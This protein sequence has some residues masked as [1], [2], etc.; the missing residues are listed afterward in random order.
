MLS[1]DHYLLIKK[2]LLGEIFDGFEYPCNV[3]SSGYRI[4]YANRAFCRYYGYKIDQVI[5]LS[6]K[7]LLPKN[8]QPKKITDLQKQIIIRKKP[9]VG[10]IV[11]VNSQGR[12]SVVFLKVVP[13]TPLSSSYPVAH[14]SISCDRAKKDAMLIS[15]LGRVS[16]FAYTYD[17]KAPRALPKI[18]SYQRGDRQTEIVKMSDLGYSTK[19][20]AAVMGISVSTV[21]FVKWK[22][23]NKGSLKS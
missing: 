13:I 23:A 1:T 6:P 17:L 12:E 7:V 11:N 8:Y 18:K 16:N 4:I 10:E 9:F 3:I 22:M 21:G 5:G 20:I 14:V 2:S 15:L 19:E